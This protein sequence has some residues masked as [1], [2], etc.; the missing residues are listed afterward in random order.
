[1]PSRA[2]GFLVVCLPF[3]PLSF[4][5]YAGRCGS[6]P[7]QDIAR[8]LDWLFLTKTPRMSGQVSSP[9]QIKD[10]AIA[11]GFV[12][13]S[14]ISEMALRACLYCCSRLSQKDAGGPS[15]LS[16]SSAKSDVIASSPQIIRHKQICES[17]VCSQNSAWVSSRSSRR[18][19]S[20]APGGVDGKYCSSG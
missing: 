10:Y 20:V 12:H 5:R 19:A 11:T 18:S 8:N 13:R 6:L 16:S 2:G 4:L 7:L 14:G 1:M 3:V 15:V 17:F 9:K